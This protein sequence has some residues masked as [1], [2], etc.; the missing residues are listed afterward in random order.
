MKPASDRDRILFDDIDRHLAKPTNSINHEL[1]QCA[2][3]PRQRNRQISEGFLTN[4]KER[5]ES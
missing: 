5:L 4:L 1:D 2:P 3:T